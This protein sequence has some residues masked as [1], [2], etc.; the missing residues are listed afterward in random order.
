MK[1]IKYGRYLATG[2][3]LPQRAPQQLD[4]L[5]KKIVAKLKAWEN[6]GKAVKKP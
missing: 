1:Q 2:P 6:S 3:I 4:A 5:H